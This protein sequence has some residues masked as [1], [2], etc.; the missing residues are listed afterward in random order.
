MKKLLVMIFLIVFALGVS[1]CKKKNQTVVPEN[2]GKVGLEVVENNSLTGWL[3]RG[4]GVECTIEDPD[5]NK[6]VVQTKNNKV[7]MSGI[8]YINMGNLNEASEPEMNGVSITDG[9]WMYTWSGNEGVKMNL[10][11]MEEMAGEFSDE[12]PEDQKTWEESITELEDENVDYNCK[13]KRLSDDLFVP[14]KNV[15]F[16]DYSTLM[17]D[18]MNSS[19][20]FQNQL[21]NQGELD[22][23]EMEAELERLKAQ[24]GLEE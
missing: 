3:K 6:M 21:Q 9:D 10:K 1:G 16:M 24:Y 22:T 4:K 20:Q 5:G 13:E 2:K 12:E 8:P 15:N 19:K 17:E 18:M 7:R 11:K 14:P 23:D